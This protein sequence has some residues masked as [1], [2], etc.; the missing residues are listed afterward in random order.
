[1]DIFTWRVLLLP[2]SYQFEPGTL[3]ADVVVRP[4]DDPYAK[5]SWANKPFVMWVCRSLFP[6]DTPTNTNPSPP[7]RSS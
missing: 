1:V 3:P 4:V 6:V 5:I 7:D 2:D